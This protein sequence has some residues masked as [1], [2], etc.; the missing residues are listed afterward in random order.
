MPQISLTPPFMA[1]TPKSSVQGVTLYCAGEGKNNAHPEFEVVSVSPHSFIFSTPI[2]EI[3]ELVGI[4]IQIM[5][6]HTQIDI[7]RNNQNATFL[8]IQ[9]KESDD[10]DAIFNEVGFALDEWQVLAGNVIAARVDKKPL[11]IETMQVLCEFCAVRMMRVLQEASESDESAQ[12]VQKIIQREFTG[13]SFRAYADEY[14][15]RERRNR[16]PFQ[17]HRVF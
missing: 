8:K 12:E 9:C 16:R 6:V 14:D 10:T 15:T 13:K 7:N 5:R 11:S 1:A 17:L 4:P 2:C 3:S